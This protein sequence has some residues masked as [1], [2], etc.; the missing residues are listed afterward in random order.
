LAVVSRSGWYYE[1]EPEA[2]DKISSFNKVAK[3]WK[4]AKRE[5]AY[6]IVP[7]RPRKDTGQEEDTERGE[8]IPA[9]VPLETVVRRLIGRALESQ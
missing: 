1:A 3:S 4:L 7:Y 8:A 5:G 2:A 6:L 9:E